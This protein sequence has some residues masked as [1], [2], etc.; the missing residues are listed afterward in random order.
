MGFIEIHGSI[1]NL[2]HITK[3]YRDTSH[4]AYEMIYEIHICTIDG[5]EEVFHYSKA[6][7]EKMKDDW[8]YLREKV[9]I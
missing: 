8:K 7:E 1:I 6:K 9:F 2:N 4:G 3:M 5:K